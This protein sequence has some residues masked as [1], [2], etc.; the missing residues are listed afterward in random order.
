M[1]EF[2]WVA[3]Q[4]ALMALKDTLIQQAVLAIDTESDSLFSYFDKVCLLQISD[5]SRHYIIDPLAVDITPLDSLFADPDIVKIFHAAEYDVMTLRRDYG[6]RFANLF[7]TMLAARL[8]QWPKCG[9]ANLLETHFDIQQNKRFQR[10]NWG[11]RPLSPAAL[12]YACLDTAYL[13]ALRE[14]QMA[15]LARQN[16]LAAATDAFLQ[17]AL[18]RMPLRMFNAADFW[19]IKGAHRLSRQQ[20]AMLQ[21][22]YQWR[23]QQARRLDRP[24]FKVVSDQALMRL[25]QQTPH[26]QAQLEKVKGLND[27][28]AQTQASAILQL[29]KSPPDLLPDQ[30]TSRRLRRNARQRTEL[31]LNWRNQ[32]AQDRQVA[33]QQIFTAAAIRRIARRNPKTR[34]DLQAIEELEIWQVDA[35]ARD[36]LRVLH[37]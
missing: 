24:T 26:T 18:A 9:L 16:K 37:P 23:D 12:S 34:A 1:P 25:V 8:L 6:F 35:Y 19:Q 21:G 11:R 4:A 7:D 13:H 14:I 31:L 33:P 28:L 30:R 29:L 32:L 20:Q 22:L 15:A 36:I 27:K 3:D 5:D 17:V 2:T 10:Y